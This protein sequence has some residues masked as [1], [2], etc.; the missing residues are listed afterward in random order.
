[1]EEKFMNFSK[2]NLDYTS[3][4]EKSNLNLNYINYF[5]ILNNKNKC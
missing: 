2:I 1:M 4:Y 5:N 3:L